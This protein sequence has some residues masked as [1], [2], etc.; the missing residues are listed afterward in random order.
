MTVVLKFG[1]LVQKYLMTSIFSIH[2]HTKTVKQH[3]LRRISYLAILILAIAIPVGNRKVFASSIDLTAQLYVDGHTLNVATDAKDVQGVI[4]SAGIELKEKDL[5]EPA[6]STE[7]TDGYK[8][9]IHRAS[10]VTI[11]DKDANLEIE[12]AQKTASAIAKEAGLTIAPEDQL[13]LSRASISIDNPKPGLSLKIDRADDVTLDLYGAIT[14]QKTQAETVGEF[15]KEKDIQLQQGDTLLL[16]LETPITPGMG[17]AVK[18]DS[19]EVQVIEEEIPMPVEQIKDVNKEKGFKEVQTP[20]STGSKT[21]TYEI[22][23]QNGVEIS[24]VALGEVI[25]KPAVKQV[26]II[27]AKE[28]ARSSGGNVS[29]Q[30]R[31]LMAA[32]GIPAADFEHAYQ[33]IQ[34]ESGWNSSARNRSSGA[35]GLVQAL[36]C[37][38]LGPN[39]SDPIVAL[40]WGNSYVNGRYGGWAGAV[41]HN[42]SRGWY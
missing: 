38:K 35:C 26:E 4:N 7:I 36:P 31:E 5:V 27:G 11:K 33:L 15:L 9:N 25:N 21:V 28:V 30:A 10:S 3:P 22:S 24:K 40:R 14:P 42:K 8:I 20:G 6:L 37:S 23:K 34:K 18:N 39:W 19:R 13:E 32:A 29:A 2:N 16:P 41:S 17:I 12:T 1:K